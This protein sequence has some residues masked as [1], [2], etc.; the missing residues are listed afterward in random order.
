[1]SAE[2]GA[3]FFVALFF[4]LIIGLTL[5]HARIQREFKIDPTWVALAATPGVLWLVLSGRVTEMTLPGGVSFKAAALQAVSLKSDGEK[6]SPDTIEMGP[7]GGV[8]NLEEL[9]R[10]GA[11]ALTFELG[12]SYYNDSAIQQY[13]SQL[14]DL[15]YLIFTEPGGAYA[16]FAPA[17]LVRQRMA[18]NELPLADLIAAKKTDQIPGFNDTSVSKNDSRA[19][20]LRLMDVAQLSVVPV[21]DADRRIAGML[22]RDKL[23]SSIVADLV[24]ES[25]KKE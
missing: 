20:A 25:V 2:Y 3:V 21:V 22:D 9:K 17:P 19:A 7:K 24:A 10:R 11:V 6:V 4:A 18:D 14:P 16:G 1:M 23:T 5:I 8:Q 13:L 12:S 15:R